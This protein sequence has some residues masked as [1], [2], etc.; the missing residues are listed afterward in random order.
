VRDR[1][2]LWNLHYLYANANVSF[3]Q[4][5]AGVPRGRVNLV[6]F[7]FADPWFKA[8]HAKRRVVQGPLVDQVAAALQESQGRCYVSSDVVELALEM[9]E[10]FD[11]CSLLERDDRLKWTAEGWLQENPFGVPTE[12]EIA[13]MR[14]PTA[15]VYRAMF[16]VRH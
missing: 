5:V 7:Q 4:I 10:H 3:A 11:A 8:R 13:V 6:C 14:E 1:D 9:R 2:A 15:R 16:R 12:R